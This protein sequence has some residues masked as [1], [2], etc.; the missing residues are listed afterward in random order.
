MAAGWEKWLGLPEV[1]EGCAMVM[2]VVNRV[3]DLAGK[4]CKRGWCGRLAM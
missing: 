3:I 1:V 4:Q 2:E